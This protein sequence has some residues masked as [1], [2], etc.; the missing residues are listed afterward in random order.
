MTLAVVV[1]CL[2]LSVCRS[3][4]V[5]CNDNCSV[6]CWRWRTGRCRRQS[7]TSEQHDD[8]TTERSPM[9]ERE[10]VATVNSWVELRTVWSVMGEID[11]TCVLLVRELVALS[12]AFIVHCWNR[13]HT[14]LTALRTITVGTESLFPAVFE[15]LGSKRIGATSLTFRGHLTSSVTSRDHLILHKPFPIGGRWNPSLCL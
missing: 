15:M 9:R 3:E 13:H 5:W 6:N 1:C 4:C 2:T 10:L 8:F 14:R 7:W 11:H 12:L